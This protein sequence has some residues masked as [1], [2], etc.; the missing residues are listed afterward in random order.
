[1][2]YC[3]KEHKSDLPLARS[4]KCN[5]CLKDI[6][7]LSMKNRGNCLAR[8]HNV[9]ALITVKFHSV[10]SECNPFFGSDK[11]VRYTFL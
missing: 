2:S 1:M 11:H 5:T 9:Y 6:R 10:V 4:L 8:L 7:D 3:D